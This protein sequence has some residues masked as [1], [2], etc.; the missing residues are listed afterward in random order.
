M[1][2]PYLGI[3]FVSLAALMFQILLTRIFSVATWYYFAFFAISVAMFGF[4]VGAI[5]VYFFKKY[6]REEKLFERLAIFS[7]AFAITIDIGLLIFLSIPFAPRFTGVGIFSTTLSYLAISI[8]YVCAGIVVCL[9][10]TRFPKRIGHIYAADLVGAAIGALLIFPVLNVLDAPTAIFLTGALAALGAICFSRSLSSDRLYKASAIVFLA[11]T[12][13]MG[14]NMKYKVVTVEWTKSQYNRP[15]SEAWNVISRIAV[16]PAYWTEEPYGWGISS[17]YKAK[18][19]IGEMMLDMDGVSE[20]PLT[21]YDGTDESIE[22]VKY[23]VTS[24]AHY[25][26]DDARVF[27]IGVGGG[28][29]ILAAKLFKQKQVVGVEI[30]DKILSMVHDKYGDLTGHMDKWPGVFLVNDEARSAITRMDAKFDIIQASCIATWSAT[31]AGAFSLAENSLYTIE[32]WD[33]F[34]NHLTDNGVM[35]FNRW[36]APDYPAQLLRLTALAVETLKKNG[37]KDPASHIAIVR[38]EIRPNSKMPSATILVSKKPFDDET[39][40]RLRDAT[41]MLKFTLIFD[42]M[43]REKSD[44]RFAEMVDNSISGNKAYFD[45]Q[46]LDLTPPTD[47]KPFFFY[48]LRGADIFKFTAMDFSEQR[49][50]IQ[51]TRML[52]ILLGVSAVLSIVFII[53]PLVYMRKSVPLP[54]NWALVGLLF[55]AS[56]GFGYIMIEISQLQRLILFLGHPMYSTTVVLFS[57]LFASGLGAY[58]TTKWIKVEQGSKVIIAIMS[59]LLVLLIFTIYMQPQILASFVQEGIITRIAISML[60]LF[61]IGF[62]MGIPFP[63]GFSIASKSFSAHTPWFWAVNGATSVLSSVLTVC[64]SISWGFTVAMMTGTLCYLLAA[65]SLLGLYAIREKG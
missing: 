32:G 6:F 58:T 49:F 43:D 62:L 42:P 22:H 53:A 9:C 13:F 57:M 31:A 8:P 20:T 24:I 1:R 30:N 50:T 34:Y 7:I 23:D 5:I 10:L 37:V 38:S 16:Y 21:Y 15:L 17:T 46:I 2:G 25:I 3:F 36:F 54:S 44:A 41:E 28:R 19:P 47:D 64:I 55:F 59:L 26:K 60:F 52:Y 35:S 39:L 18:K 11:L 40:K 65:I 45:E 4:T 61:P 63:L 12:I 56:I 14:A 48:M 29:D 27:V 33:V 51:G